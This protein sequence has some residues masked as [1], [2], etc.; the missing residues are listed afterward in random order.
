MSTTFI[1]SIL[2]GILVFIIAF[3]YINRQVE[4]FAEED[5]TKDTTEVLGSL[6]KMLESLKTSTSPE[7]FQYIEDKELIPLKQT[8]MIYLSTFSDKTH[9]DDTVDIYVP[10][11]QKWNNYVNDNQSFFIV[12]NNA[13]PAAIKLNGLALKNVTLNGIHSDEINPTDYILGPFS[14]S[15]YVKFNSISF[16]EPNP[17]PIEI[18]DIFVESPNYIKLLLEPITI[19]KA[20]GTN[21]LDKDNVNF[22]L[23]VGDSTKRSSVTVPVS[24]LLS[25]GN[26]VLFTMVYD[27]SSTTDDATVK[28]ILGEDE[29]K[30]TI[31]PKPKLIL[32]NSRIRI[33]SSGKLDA[34]LYSFMFYKSA[35][36]KETQKEIK[37][38]VEKQTT[39]VN[40]IL[41]S[42]A[43]MTE[44][45]IKQLRSYVSDQTMT[46]DT[47]KKQ[48]EKCKASV[49]KVQKETPFKYAINMQGTSDVTMDDLQECSVLN[50]KDRPF[51]KI[52]AE[53]AK[54]ADST[55]TSKT[56]T[57]GKPRFYID[58]PFLK[59]IL[60]KKYE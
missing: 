22:I 25:N 17:S 12:S 44:D 6:E 53:A 28:L 31:T 37:D 52:T 16:A 47:L 58:V 27:D 21:E 51:K 60:P 1:I 14:A 34:T 41:T 30:H 4:P 11:A 33:N 42:L 8:L 46:V 40:N 39:G 38:Y 15:F 56:A 5:T 18:M 49:T 10:Q 23:H 7:N 32:G 3:W 43:S 59:D 50:I 35:I 29:Y 13:L 55:A 54:I 48:L 9:Y 57:P 36:T 2:I 24:T 20:D 26:K 45:Q 19:T